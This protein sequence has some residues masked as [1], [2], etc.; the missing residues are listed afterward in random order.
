M[1][2]INFNNLVKQLLPWHKRKPVRLTLLGGALSPL[3]T[4]FARFDSWRDDVRR[5]INISAQVAVLEGYLRHKY[6]SSVSLY[7]ETFDDRL[8]EVYLEAEGLENTMSVPLSVDDGFIEIP[9]YGEVREK[10]GNVDFVVY[11]PANL[12]LEQIRAEIELYRQAGVRYK[13]IQRQYE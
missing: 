10:F 7:I 1:I 3:A 6:D 2:K 8:I 11:I 13:I 4:L 5:R 9:M 12:D